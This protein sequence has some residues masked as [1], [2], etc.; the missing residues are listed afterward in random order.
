[1]EKAI[2]AWIAQGASEVDAQLYAKLYGKPKKSDPFLVRWNIHSADWAR[3][4]CKANVKAVVKAAEAAGRKIECIYISGKFGSVY[5]DLA[6]G[7]DETDT[8]RVSDHERTSEEHARPVF[9]IFDRATL[10]AAIKAL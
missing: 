10:A 2:A 8:I 6:A 7:D 9:N 4:K 5:I 3:V 1:M